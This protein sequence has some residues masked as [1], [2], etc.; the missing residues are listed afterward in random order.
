MKAAHQTQFSLSRI[1]WKHRLSHGGVL[2][3]QRLGR[4]GRPLSNRDPVHL[5][6]KAQR[7]CL[8]KGLGL[9][10]YKRFFLIQSLVQ[11][12]SLRF[13]VKVE[14]ISIQGDHIHLLVRSRRR[15]ALQNFLRVV[16]GQIAQEFIRRE[17][18]VVTDTP[19]R[20]TGAGGKKLK[21]WLHRPFTRVIK[22]R[23]ALVIVRNYI[24]LNE[25]EAYGEIVYQKKRLRG[26]SLSDWQ[27]LWT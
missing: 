9:R 8:G 19:D 1:P 17:I 27:A 12:Y 2:R 25:K 14:Q 18:L 7:L 26:L 15:R 11:R 16:S 20:K 23:R 13:S 24:Q 6:L 3:N 22:G 4:R 10:T 21:L 5:V